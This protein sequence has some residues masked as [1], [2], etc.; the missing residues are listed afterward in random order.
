MADTQDLLIEIG[1]EELPPKA[2]GRLAEAFAAGIENQLSQHGLAFDAI[3][4]FAAP[5]RLAVLVRGLVTAQ[6]DRVIER[7]GPAVAAAFDAA[8]TPSKAAEGFARS[9]GVAVADL[10]QVDT[11]KGA[12]L[13]FNQHQPGRQTAELVPE[14]V[15]RSLA[16]LPIPKRMRWGDGDAEFVRPVHW[17]VLLFGDT[18]ID[19]EVL[20]LKAGRLTYGHRFHHPGSIE[21][22]SPASYVEQLRSPGQVLVDMDERRETIYAQVEK[23]A[24]DVGAIAIIDEALLDEVTALN[25]WPVPVTG[26]FDTRFLEVPAEALI[27]TM[28]EHQKYFPV[29]DGNG[30]LLPRFITISNIASRDPDQ[31]RAGNERVIRPRFSDAAFFWSQDLKR[32]LETHIEG[33]KGVVFQDKLG[34]LYEKSQ[35]I[36]NLAGSI[37]SEL[38]LDPT[39]AQRAAAL[40]KCDLLTNMVGEFPALQGTMGRYYAERGGEAPD[41]AAAMEELYLPRHAGDQLPETLCGRAIAIADRLDTLVGIFAIGQ[42]PTGEKDPFGLRRAALGVLRIMIETP[43]SLDLEALLQT[44]AASLVDRAPAE[45]AVPE[46]FDYMMERLRAYYAD[47]EIPGDVVDAVLARRPTR[48]ADFD[49]RVRAVTAFRDLPEAE[50]L[51]AANKRIRNI[52]RKTEESF[53]ESPDIQLLQDASEKALASQIEELAPEVTPLF[54]QGQYS[55]ALQRLSR[56]RGPVDTFFDDVMVM[57]EDDSLRKNRLALLSSLSGLFLQVADISRLQQ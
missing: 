3:Q 11:P 34:T 33:L 26:S 35:R 46:V 22:T 40:C 37:A 12:W 21:I 52:L 2:L 16:G 27:K 30:K 51:A 48:P 10:K 15:Q 47:R 14:M 6:A 44:A 18:I 38:G 36:A 50:S 9:C 43:L 24:A 49:Q 57:C 4:R 41:V 53:P 28:Q 42:R 56:L 20:G 5:R 39:L 55:E 45:A 29:M 13:V 31:V 19:G 23:T 7:K 8:G 1:T 54:A 25:E 17:V 32:P